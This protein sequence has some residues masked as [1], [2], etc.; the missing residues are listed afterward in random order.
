MIRLKRE[1]ES[2]TMSGIQAWWE[3]HHSNN[4]ERWLTGSSVKHY[5]TFFQVPLADAIMLEI[6]VG[7]AVASIPLACRNKELHCVD[8]SRRAL[9]RVEGKVTKTWHTSEIDQLPKNYFDIAVSML[10]A[11]HVS[12]AELQR[13]LDCIIP[14][15]KEDG[16]FLLQ[17][18]DGENWG[19]EQLEHSQRVGQSVRTPET[20]KELIDKAGGIVTMEVPPEHYA[21]AQL[22]WH[23]FHIKRSQ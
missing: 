20:A 16:V 1:N 15:L 17:F 12:D 18:S 8:I 23:G 5:E 10:V 4:A 2:D 9:K 3:E 11:Q 14:A 21:H 19:Y 7:L 13:Q 22:T 6:G